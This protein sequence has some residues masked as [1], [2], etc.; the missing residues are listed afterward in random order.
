[1]LNNFQQK[2]DFIKEKNDL[3]F[4]EIIILASI[5]EK[6]TSLKRRKKIGCFCFFIIV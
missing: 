1:M 3:S 6:E 2:V 4:Y 5:V